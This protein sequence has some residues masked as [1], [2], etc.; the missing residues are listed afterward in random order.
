M[1]ALLSCPVYFFKK[2]VWFPKLISLQSNFSSGFV[3][4]QVIVCAMFVFIRHP[5][6]NR[7]VNNFFILQ[8]RIRKK[9]K[10]VTC[11]QCTVYIGTYIEN[12][13]RKKRSWKPGKEIRMVFFHSSSNWTKKTRRPS[14][15]DPK[16]IVIESLRSVQRDGNGIRLPAGLSIISE[17]T[18]KHGNVAKAER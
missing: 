16:W 9:D 1:W 3:Y 18:C 8:K 2:I 4:G 7:G 10:R 5:E 17:S 15:Q 12:S 13:G 11:T 14:L 6:I